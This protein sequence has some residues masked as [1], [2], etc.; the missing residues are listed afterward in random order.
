M[1]TIWSEIERIQVNGSGHSCVGFSPNLYY[2]NQ[3]N[4][5]IIHFSNLI[6]KIF[7]ENLH[8]RIKVSNI[9]N[10][11]LFGMID[12]LLKHDLGNF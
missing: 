9:R 6:I 12:E 7:N 5:L 4:I 11:F 1:E 8:L 10:K 3:I 2:S